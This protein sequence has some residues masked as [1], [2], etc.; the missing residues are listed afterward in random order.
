MAFLSLLE[1]AS[2]YKYIFLE[3]LF[4]EWILEWRPV[5]IFFLTQIKEEENEVVFIIFSSQWL[6]IHL[7]KRPTV[8]KL[9]SFPDRD[10]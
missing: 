4:A 8:E 2:M 7:W 10:N 3:K 9:F 1:E 6:L 5:I